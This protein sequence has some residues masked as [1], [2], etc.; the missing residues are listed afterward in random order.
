MIG[1][2][3]LESKGQSSGV[4]ADDHP[5]HTV[6]HHA[7][8]IGTTMKPSP[9]AFIL[10]IGTAAAFSSPGPGPRAARFPLCAIRYRFS[11]TQ[12]SVEFVVPL[13]RND[14][15][16]KDVT[17]RVT[18]ESVFLAISGRTLINGPL[19]G[20]VVPE[21]LEWAIDEE[22]RVLECVLEKRDPSRWDN[23]TP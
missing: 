21:S 13:P 5:A 19:L 15:R 10:M 8:K 14:V 3:A 23:L 18:P 7:F 16:E 2:P 20:S 6:L 1:S 4:A 9:A 12:S 22:D 17:L 11:Q